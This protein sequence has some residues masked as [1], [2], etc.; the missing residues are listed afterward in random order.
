[1]S[2][3]TEYHRRSEPWS[4]WRLFRSKIFDRPP[5]PEDRVYPLASVVRARRDFHG[6]SRIV[7]LSYLDDIEL[8]SDYPLY[9]PD[10][11]SKQANVERLYTR[12]DPV[13]PIDVTLP[14]DGTPTVPRKDMPTL[15]AARALA[16][17]EIKV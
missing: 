2:Y 4:F 7:P 1:M 10:E 3:L 15:A 14:S 17:D 13:A 12:G 9:E 6:S 11:A 5:E 8:P 16:L